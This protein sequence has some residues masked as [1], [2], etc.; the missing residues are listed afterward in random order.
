M[1]HALSLFAHRFEKLS[2]PLNLFLVPKVSLEP[3]LLNTD[4]LKH[5]VLEGVRELFPEALKHS[6]V[7]LSDDLV[8]CIENL[9][10][11]HCPGHF[12]GGGLNAF[13]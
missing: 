6:A 1:L 12:I 8:L 2:V 9:D 13:I 10:Q 5:L 3:I 4:R 7:T 11:G